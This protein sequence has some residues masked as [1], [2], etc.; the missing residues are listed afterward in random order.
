MV[1]PE[2]KL[3]PI[4]LVPWTDTP[5]IFLTSDEILAPDG[6]RLVD[7]FGGKRLTLDEFHARVA[8]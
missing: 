5:K 7:V 3:E 4:N 1:S 8:E 2:E 6:R